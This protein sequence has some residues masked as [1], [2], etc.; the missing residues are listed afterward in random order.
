MCLPPAP[1]RAHWQATDAVAGDGKGIV[2]STIFLRV[3]TDALPDLTLT[4]LP[5]ITCARL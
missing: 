5:G 1:S 4:D 2:D 3:Y